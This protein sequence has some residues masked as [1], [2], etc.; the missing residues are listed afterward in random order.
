M[1][2]W[3]VQFF[4]RLMCNRSRQPRRIIDRHPRGAVY[5]QPGSRQELENGKYADHDIFANGRC[6]IAVVS[7]SNAPFMLRKGLVGSGP[8][9]NVPKTSLIYLLL[10]GNR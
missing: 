5:V 10:G 2:M 6:V 3:R 9:D 8:L 1:E 7:A 4:C